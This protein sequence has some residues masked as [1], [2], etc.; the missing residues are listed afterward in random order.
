MRTRSLLTTV[1]STMLLAGAGAGTAFADGT[2]SQPSA[3][4]TTPSASASSAPASAP[5]AAPTTA[6]RPVPSASAA[7]ST[8]PASSRGGSD[9][10]GAVP[11]GA[12]NTGVPTNT[13][14]GYGAVEAVGAGL[15]LLLGGS[16]GVMLRRRT[17]GQG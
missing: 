8:A 4:P 7:P 13:S 1:A 11:S 14:N 3:A 17:K 9:Q 15:V 6:A 5:S 12:P 2:S 10:V 16:G